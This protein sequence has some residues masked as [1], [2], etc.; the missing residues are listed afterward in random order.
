MKRKILVS[1]SMFLI[2]L[3]CQAQTNNREFFSLDLS[4]SLTSI[5]NHGLGIGINYERSLLDYLSIKGNFGHMT[6]TT[7]IDDVYSTSVHISLYVNYYPL[8]GGLDKLYISAGGG[9]D[10]MN[11][12]GKGNLPPTTQDILI[13]ITP[14]LGWKFNVLRF[15]IIDVS[16]GYKY[17]I[18][19]T[20]NYEDIR[21]FVNSGFNFGLG[22]KILFNQIGSK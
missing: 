3:P 14:Q 7:S 4:Y 16:V 2:S 21:D 6:L 11:Y 8:G 10:F 22:F 18:Y 1:L 13:H 5:L 19:E 20:Q 12:F 9:C 15:L 17:L